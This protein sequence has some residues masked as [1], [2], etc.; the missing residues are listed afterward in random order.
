MCPPWCLDRDLS[1]YAGHPVE[2]AGPSCS[3]EI[4]GDGRGVFV[5]PVL[6][7]KEDSPV[8]GFAIDGGPELIVPPSQARSLAAFLTRAA[9]IAEVLGRG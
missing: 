8:V 1:D 6:F 3:V 9:D 2:H 7:D 5:R 4:P